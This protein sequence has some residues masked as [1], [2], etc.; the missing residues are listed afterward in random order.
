MYRLTQSQPEFFRAVF[1]SLWKE[2]GGT[3][4]RDVASG[5]VAPNAS[6]IVWHDSR[7]LA[8]Q[9]RTINKQSNNLMA[10]LVLLAVGA[11]T[12]GKGATVATAESAATQILIRQGVNTQ[13]WRIDNGS[14]LSRDARVTAEGLASMLQVIWRSNYMPEFI[15]SLAI[16]GVDGTVRRRLRDDE[17]QGRAHLK[18]GTLRD[19]R[20]LSGYVLG[21]SGKRYILVSMVNDSRS[22]AVRPFDDAVV[23][24]LA[25]R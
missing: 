8:E 21:A 10:T 12:N 7:P 19:A 14:G 5:T 1:K 15:S 24:W 20:A 18:T 13:G 4:A 22:A 3:L 6:A 2:L 25:T 17:V 11:E 23:K 16:S 9:I